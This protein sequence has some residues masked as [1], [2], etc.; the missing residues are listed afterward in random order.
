MLG[1]SVYL[2]DKMA[3]RGIGGRKGRRD[4]ISCMIGWKTNQLPMRVC[5]SVSKLASDS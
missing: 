3:G 1:A 4:I 2:I 5:A